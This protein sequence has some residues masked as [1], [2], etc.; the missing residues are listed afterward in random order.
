MGR[1]AMGGTDGAAPPLER[2]AP[3]AG[4][5][6]ACSMERVDKRERLVG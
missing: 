2:P 6:T 5:H 3:E 1:A 4:V